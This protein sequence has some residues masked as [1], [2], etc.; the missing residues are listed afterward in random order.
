MKKLLLLLL[1]IPTLSF[2]QGIGDSYY[3][4]MKSLTNDKTYYNI[5]FNNDGETFN[6]ITAENE[7]GG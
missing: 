5:K 3:D 7:F 4:T 1:L 6:N 2:S